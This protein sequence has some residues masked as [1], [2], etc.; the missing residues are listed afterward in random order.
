MIG[1][2]TC[3]GSWEKLPR[4][5]FPWVGDKDRPLIILSAQ[6]S[7]GVAYNTILDAYKGKGMDG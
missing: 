2:G 4:N 7:I 1:Y 3:V 6:P 5:I